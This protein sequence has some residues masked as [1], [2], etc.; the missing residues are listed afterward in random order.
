[1]EFVDI[2][3]ADR[4]RLFEFITAAAAAESRAR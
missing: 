1:V 4:K 2:S 3:A